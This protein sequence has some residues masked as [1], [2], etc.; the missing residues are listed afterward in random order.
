MNK[1]PPVRAITTINVFSSSYFAAK[2]G[3]TKKL[4]KTAQIGTMLKIKPFNCVG[5]FKSDSTNYPI[6]EL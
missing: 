6:V 4:T 1:D 5:N 3:L 2:R